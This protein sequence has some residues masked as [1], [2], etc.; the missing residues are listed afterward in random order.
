[1]PHHIQTDFLKR[2]EVK[3]AKRHTHVH[4]DVCIDFVPA[5]ALH[6]PSSARRPRRVGQQ[7]V[8]PKVSSKH[9]F[10]PAASHR[11]VGDDVVLFQQ[12]HHVLAQQLGD[13]VVKVFDVP[14]R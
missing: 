7:V 4:L 3:V 1:M 11:R 2:L 8:V 14:T 6:Q 5:D 13:V 10:H 12:L 9:V